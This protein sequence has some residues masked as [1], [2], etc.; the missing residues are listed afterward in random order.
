MIRIRP[1]GMT[2]TFAKLGKL[3]GQAKAEQQRIERLQRAAEQLRQIQY[4]REIRELQ[5]K[6][7]IEAFNRSKAWAL[8]KMEIAS[9]MDFQQQEAN[10]QQKQAE[11]NAK[12]KAI[13]ESNI[14]N[15]EEK[16]L[17][18]AQIKTGVPVATTAMR[19]TTRQPSATQQMS[20]ILA[21]IT[22][23]TPI[24]PPTEKRIRVVSPEGKKG[25]ILENEWG[26]YK[27]R[28]FERI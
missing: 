3:A 21:Q 19:Q 16:S 11:L 28:G 5:H 18:V 25:T 1:K 22:A 6:W 27:S 26:M 2:T 20:N 23:E 7:E 14:L 10:K 15:E 17:W 13:Q 12:I 4:Q 9:R 24:S 8:E